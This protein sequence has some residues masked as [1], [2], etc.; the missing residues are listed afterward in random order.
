[1]HFAN[2]NH[3]AREQLVNQWQQ[4]VKA[5]PDKQ[6]AILAQRWRDVKPLND[7]VRQVYQQQG[8]VGHQ[9][10]EAECA[11][12]NQ[13]ITFAFS[14]GERV[15]FTRNDYKR[16]FTNGEL[17]TIELVEQ[18][19]N[20]IRFTIRCD[21]GRVESFNQSDYCD[22]KNRLYLVQAYAT[23][24]YAS[25]GSTIDGDTFIYYTSSMD[26]AATYVAGSRAKDKCHWFV[27]NEEL[28]ILSGTKDKGI[29]ATEQTRLTT[30][31]RCMS[32]N[33]KKGL[34]I[35]YLAEQQAQPEAQHQT[36]YDLAM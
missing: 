12:S 32:A 17:G 8:I 22:E 5:N 20:D 1:M 29:E 11:I 19:D 14:T 9:N 24:V 4:Y 25:Q 13:Y 35:E 23:T 26:R 15:R 7:L 30:L 27:N 34:A 16:G 21:D 33:R 31:A 18:L 28:D 2:N 6:T 3:Q 10:I 36:E